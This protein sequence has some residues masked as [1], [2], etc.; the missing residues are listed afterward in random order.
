MGLGDLIQITDFQRY[1]GQDVL[2][3]F[4]YRIT[5]ITGLDNTAYEVMADWFEADWVQLVK[6][7]QTPDLVHTSIE[8]R[9]MSNGLD[10]YSLPINVPGID[11]TGGAVS[12]PSYVSL[13]FKLIRESLATRNGYKRIGGLSDAN[14]AGNTFTFPNGT[15]RAAIEAFLAS[16]WIE[17]VVTLAEP[18]IV[19][20][21]IV[22]PAG[23]GYVYASIGAAQY[24][25]LG[26]QNTRKAGRGN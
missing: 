20:R 4:Y 16:D 17:G 6:G 23:T 3:V 19:K 25:Q 26:T 8:I 9:N 13:G 12:S 15:I 18:V 1:L 14:I 24:T 10:F 21:P 22:V 11:N 2:N 7:L 5:S